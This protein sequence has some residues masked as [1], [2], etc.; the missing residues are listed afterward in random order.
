MFPNYQDIERRKRLRNNALMAGAVGGGV[1]LARSPKARGVVGGA[2]VRALAGAT[3]FFERSALGRSGAFERANLN[4]G[5]EGASELERTVNQFERFRRFSLNAQQARRVGFEHLT[6]GQTLARWTR[7]QALSLVSP[8]RHPIDLFHTSIPPERAL[9]SSIYRSRISGLNHE[10]VLTDVREMLLSV[11]RT[12]ISE[13]LHGESTRLFTK[14]LQDRAQPDIKE[15]WIGVGAEKALSLFGIKKDT[16]A[17]SGILEHLRHPNLVGE[18]HTARLERYLEDVKAR[19]GTDTLSSTDKAITQAAFY[20][21]EGGIEDPARILS[22]LGTGRLTAGNDTVADVSRLKQFLGAADEL[23]AEHF[24]IPLSPLGMGIQP[25]RLFPWTRGKKNSPFQVASAGQSQPEFTAAGLPFGVDSSGNLER[26]VY[27]IGGRLFSTNAEGGVVSGGDNTWTFWD[28]RFGFWKGFRRTRDTHDLPVG[29]VRQGAERFGALPGRVMDTLGLDMQSEPSIFHKIRNITSRYLYP[30]NYPDHPTN[31]LN[32]LLAGDTDKLDSVLEAATRSERVDYG[33][34]RNALLES[35]RERPGAVRHDTTPKKLMDLLATDLT[36]EQAF[37]AIREIDKISS[38]SDLSTLNLFS[39]SDRFYGTYTKSFARRFVEN[40]VGT[41]AE[42]LHRRDNPLDILFGRTAPTQGVD[43]I[44]QVLLEETTAQLSRTIPGREVLDDTLARL[45]GETKTIFWAMNRKERLLSHVLDRDSIAESIMGEIGDFAPDLKHLLSSKYPA[46]KFWEP[47]EEGIS[48]VYAA[49]TRRILGLQGVPALIGDIA[50]NK[51]IGRSLS[52]WFRETAPGYGDAVSPGPLYHAGYRLNRMLSEFG[53]GLPDTDMQHS[54]GMFSGLVFKRALPVFAAIEGWKYVNHEMHNLGIPGFDDMLANTR[55]NLTLGVAGVSDFLGI[56]DFAKKMVSLTPGAEDYLQPKSYE[57]TKEYLNEGFDP[58]RKG[59]FWALSR[60][61]WVGERVQYYKPSWY[62]LAKSHWRE[63]DTADL[64]SDD[65]W[66]HSIIPTPTHPLSTLWHFLDPYWFENKHKKDRPYVQSSDMFD[67]STSIGVV[68]NASLGGFLKPKKIFHPEY[69]PENLADTLSRE[70]WPYEKDTDPEKFVEFQSGGGARTMHRLAGLPLPEHGG[71]RTVDEDEMREG[72]YGRVVAG[73]FGSGGGG[74]QGSFLSNLLG[75]S[76]PGNAGYGDGEGLGYGGN[77]SSARKTMTAANLTTRHG[78]TGAGSGLFPSRIRQDSPATPRD[79]EGPT[80]S[81]RLLRQ[82][83]DLLGIYGYMEETLGEMF[84]QEYGSLHHVIQTSEAAQGWERRAWQPEIGGL[85]GVLSELWRRVIPHKDRMAIQYNPVPNDQPSWMPGSDYKLLDASRGDPYCLTSDTLVELGNLGFILASDIVSGDYLVS[86]KGEQTQVIATCIRSLSPII[87]IKVS[88]LPAFPVRC[89]YDHPIL[90]LSIDRSSRVNTP[91]GL[92]KKSKQIPEFIKSSDLSVGDFVVYPKPILDESIPIIDMADIHT[93]SAVTDN[94]VYYRGTQEYCENREYLLGERDTPANKSTL[95]ESR[96]SLRQ[97]YKP[98]RFPRFIRLDG[99]IGKFVGLWC[100]E[101]CASDTGACSM[102]HNVSEK[103]A[104]LD[105]YNDVN[106]VPQWRPKVGTNG[107]STTFGSRGW[108]Y[109]LRYLCGSGARNKSLNNIIMKFPKDFIEGFIE[110][111]FFGDGCTFES[112]N[113]KVSSLS[114]ASYNLALQVRKILLSLHIVS[115]VI[116]KPPTLG[117]TF[118]QN[119]G[120]NWIVKISNPVNQTEGQ[121]WFWKD[122]SLFLRVNSISTCPDEETYGFMTDSETFCAVGV[123]THNTKVPFGEVRMPGAAYEQVHGIDLSSLPFKDKL[124]IKLGLRSRGEYYDDLTRLEILADIAPWSPEFRY[125]LDNIEAMAGAAG[126]EREEEIRRR[127]RGVKK[128]VATVKKSM[129]IRDYRFDRPT[130]SETFTVDQVLDANTISVKELDYPLRL[131]GY[132]AAAGRVSREALTRMNVMVRQGESPIK[133]LYR[134]FGI[135]SGSRIQVKYEKVRRDEDPLN[136]RASIYKDGVNLNRALNQLGVAEVDEED[137][138]AGA[139]DARFSVAERMYGRFAEAVGHLDTP[140]HTKFW[141][142][143]SALERYEREQVYGT[144]G[145]GWAHPIREWV[146]PTFNAAASQFPVAGMLSG[147]YFGSLF[148]KTRP[149]KAIGAL[150]GSAATIPLLSNRVA[151][152]MVTGEPWIPRGVRTKRDIEEYVDAL[153]YV[154]MSNLFHQEAELAKKE[155]GV[156][157]VEIAER[158]ERRGNKYTKEKTRLE[159]LRRK[160]RLEGDR[161]R[162]AMLAKRIAELGGENRHLEIVGP[163][164]HRALMFRERM[165]T[166]VHGWQP[167]DPPPSL[168]A[169]LPR[170][171]RE[172]ARDIVE[173]G[174]DEE[175]DRFYDLLPRYE[176]AALGNLLGQRNTPRRKDLE[177][178]FKSHPLPDPDWKGWDESFGL[179]SVRSIQAAENDQILSDM[180]LSPRQI[181]EARVLSENVPTPTLHGSTHNVER[182]L[183]QLLE[184]MGARHIRVDMEVSPSHTNE[185][186]L[187]ADVHA[188]RVSDY[189]SMLQ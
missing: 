12:R 123:A 149:G 138:S 146:I 41:L 63:S 119:T 114:T 182:K 96:G 177:E 57:E 59:R 152:E 167:G 28:D 9:A 137:W 17:S 89:S 160:A 125:Q 13:D 174:T 65:Y 155:E 15:N 112:K 99:K 153:T 128:R 122:D 87:E 71:T 74:S 27:S 94:Y 102:A 62:R 106:I 171:E 39:E 23:I 163:H 127:L 84:N 72:V 110:G 147:A 170:Y 53:L 37:S 130:E 98:S 104:V 77:V 22:R 186:H 73:K 31:A 46:T 189:L 24:H 117:N 115:S 30:E 172:I 179:D 131:A 70:D 14:M 120:M 141:N 61:P 118:V 78:P 60:T 159:K 50:A 129:T 184:G 67:N 92:Y 80:Y 36:P 18:G 82:R 144:K 100:A 136:V 6:S 150:I 154:K 56:T 143:R 33:T 139:V 185:F 111:L 157:V 176:K 19:V 86:S 69:L 133:A 29:A 1:L 44:R 107:A 68:L 161:E 151:S 116:E 135:D 187:E 79:I 32:R 124:L 121:T 40:D 34:V 58:V 91:K 175:R 5:G 4:I 162:S 126:G 183:R 49:P 103:E 93:W 88:S 11:Q 2:V 95:S 109:L 16:Y 47:V 35:L 105:I 7:E 66:A 26:D 76:S 8:T 188:D 52:S 45:T 55:A 173:H 156:D 113:R 85:G 42:A 25:L 178:Y 148:G 43:R 142:N 48:S 166:T 180:A 132:S 51:D 145:S 10:D 168:Y 54:F 140:L 83:Q 108:S 3:K 165:R 21:R 75:I 158:E 20:L 97:G 164:T 169:A 64:N 38:Y 81:Q 90:A 101:G 181:Q 134:A